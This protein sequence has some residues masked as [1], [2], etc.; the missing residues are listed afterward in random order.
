VLDGHI[1]DAILQRAEERQ[2]FVQ[3]HRALG[4]R[5]LH[6]YRLAKHAQ[7]YAHRGRA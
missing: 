3:A 7:R 4:L 6:G 5:S 2:D 1:N